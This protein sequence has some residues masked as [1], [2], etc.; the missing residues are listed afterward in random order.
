MLTAKVF[1]VFVNIN[2]SLLSQIVGLHGSMLTNVRG[3]G[4][5]KFVV[6]FFLTRELSW[7][8]YSQDYYQTNK[9]ILTIK[10]CQVE[11]KIPN[12]WN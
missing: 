6:V 2:V 7:V 3:E 8:F 5:F 12:K 10:I 9:F 11:V 1:E 4:S